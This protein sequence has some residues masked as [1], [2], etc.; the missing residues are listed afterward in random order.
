V[1][2]VAPLTIAKQISPLG[3]HSRRE[4]VCWRALVEV[5]RDIEQRRISR[6]AVARPSKTPKAAPLSAHGKDQAIRLSVN[7]V[8]F[9]L[10]L[11]LS[12]RPVLSHKHGLSTWGRNL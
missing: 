12:S 9:R 2:G 11:G 6:P 3:R 1:F 4:Q 5:H 7:I 10:R 8:L